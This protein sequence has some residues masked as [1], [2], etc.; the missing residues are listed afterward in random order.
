MNRLL[1]SVGSVVI[2]FLAAAAVSAPAQST[3]T[4]SVSNGA[5]V[6]NYTDPA[7]AQHSVTIPY[8]LTLSAPTATVTYTPPSVVAPPPP[9]TTGPSIPS[10]AKLVVLDTQTSWKGEKDAG[11]PGTASGIATTYPAVADSAHQDARSFAM[12]YTGRGGVRWSTDSNRSDY[13]STHFVYDTYVM[14]N[15]FSQL[16]NL[17][18]DINQVT[19]AGNTRILGTQCSNYSHSWEYTLNTSAAATAWHWVPSNIPCDTTKFA[20]GQWYHI[21]IEGHFDSND[22]S[23][24]D[25]VW[26]DGQGTPFS[27]A[28]GPTGRALGWAHGVVLENFQLDGANASGSA[29]VYTSPTKIYSW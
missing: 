22:N 8:T 5:I 19:A 14:S 2:A 13:A 24:Y 18:L 16:N 27:G 20:P 29:V 1:R 17:E 10:N 21:Q 6:A 7:G 25:E 11:T 3:V 26:V 28:S 4:T 23:Y 15:S 9:V 12:S